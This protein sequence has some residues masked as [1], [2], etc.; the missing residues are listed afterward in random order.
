MSALDLAYNSEG[1]CAIV[2]VIH[3]IMDWAFGEHYLEH[4]FWT[5][6]L[7]SPAA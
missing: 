4:Q 1:I 6:H 7:A 5:K 3:P 2:T